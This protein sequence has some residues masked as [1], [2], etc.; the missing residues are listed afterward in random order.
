VDALGEKDAETAQLES[1]G[2]AIIAYYLAN[3]SV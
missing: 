2:E 3:P 1:I